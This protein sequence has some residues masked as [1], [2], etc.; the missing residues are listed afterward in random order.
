MSYMGFL[1]GL[2][3]QS[4]NSSLLQ[5]FLPKNE[6]IVFQPYSG[7]WFPT[8]FSFHPYLGIWSNLINIFQMGWNHQLVFFSVPML[9]F[10]GVSVWCLS[11]PSSFLCVTVWSLSF[12]LKLFKVLHSLDIWS[13]P[14]KIPGKDVL[15]LEKN[16]TFT[17]Y[18]QEYIELYFLHGFYSLI[19]Q[20][21]NYTPRKRCV[22]TT[23]KWLEHSWK[24]CTTDAK[25]QTF[26]LFLLR[27]WIRD[28]MEKTFFFWHI[29]PCNSVFVVFFWN[30][31]F[32]LCVKR[33]YWGRDTT[34]T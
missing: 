22:A 31:R 23:R 33:F 6:R 10:G 9:N 5:L 7:W 12:Y 18:F 2:H 32:L 27:A 4:L 25:L 8:F 29:P 26:L 21:S 17:G 13:N 1:V 16:P 14:F 20:P 28:P 30:W 15:S 3:P 34:T 19:I 11:T 24:A